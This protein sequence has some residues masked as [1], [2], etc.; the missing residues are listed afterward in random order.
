MKRSH[1][2]SL[3]PGRRRDRNMVEIQVRPQL[4]EILEIRADNTAGTA[5]R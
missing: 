3:A 1:F 2:K 5:T 4:R